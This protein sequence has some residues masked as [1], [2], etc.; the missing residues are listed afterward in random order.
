VARRRDRPPD[1]G[2][3]PERTVLAWHRTALASLAVAA[4]L[5][6]LDATTG[7]RG[8]GL[9][10]ATALAAAAVSWLGGRRRAVDGTATTAPARWLLAAVA[11][12]ATAAA[13][14]AVAL[15]WPPG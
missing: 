2:L 1:R 4:L 3:Q 9:P 7:W 12:A 5:A 15:A 11:A 10:A 14:A 13:V 6:R 8:R